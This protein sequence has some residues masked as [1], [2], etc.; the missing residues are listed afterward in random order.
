MTCCPRPQQNAEVL[1]ELERLR[2]LPDPVAAARQ[3]RDDALLDGQKFEQLIQS[4]QVRGCWSHCGSY[5]FKLHARCSIASVGCRM[6][7]PIS[8]SAEVILH[9]KAFACGAC[10]VAPIDPRTARCTKPHSR[11]AHPQGVKQSQQRKLSER[12]QDLAARQEQIA[13]AAEEVEALRQ[14]VA[15]QTVN[16]ADMNRMIMERCVRGAGRGLLQAAPCV[17]ARLQ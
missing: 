7:M 1:A 2:A 4:L 8:C 3:Q 13:A 5:S 11:P 14:R 15:G 10:S 16:K 12:K 6:T 17:I 9:A